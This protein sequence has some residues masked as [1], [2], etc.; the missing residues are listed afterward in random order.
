M[1]TTMS[2]RSDK[3]KRS[4][5]PTKLSRAADKP[6]EN[7]IRL[8]AYSLYEKRRA[9]GASGDASSDWIKAERLLT[10]QPTE[11]TELD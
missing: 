8:L 11:G 2:S 4:K 7:E 6:S 9:D 1:A 5:V 3:T 10:D